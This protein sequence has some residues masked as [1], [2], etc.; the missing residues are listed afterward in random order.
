MSRPDRKKAPFH[1]PETVNSDYETKLGDPGSAPFTRGIYEEMYGKRLWTMRQY[2]GYA[3]AEESNRRYKYLLEQGINGLSVA[4]DLPTQIGYDSDNDLAKGEVGRVG[5]AVDSILDMEK[6]FDG[7]DLGSVSTSMTI[8]ATAPTLL[9][10]Y[11][12]VAES[13][14]VEAASLTGTVQNDILKEYIARGTYIYPP[15]QSMRL[16]TDLFAYCAEQMPNWNTISISGY[17]IREAGATAAQEL[18]FTFANAIAYSEAAVD[19]GLDFDSFA[20]RLSFFFNCHSDF[21]EEAA[22]FRAARRIWT[23]IAKERFKSKNPKS[24][25]LRFHTQTAGSSLTA[26]QPNVNIVRTTLQALA[27]VLGGTQ[28]LHTNSF[29]EALSL[30]T[31]EAAL[32]ALR[33]QQ[34]IAHEIGIENSADPLGG[35]WY[36]EN[37]TDE[38][39]T[40][41]FDY[42]KKIDDIGGALNAIEN[43]FIQNEIA[44]SAYEYQKAVEEGAKL[45]VGVNAFESEQEIEPETF[46]INPD[47]LEKQMEKL[48]L[49]KKER[50]SAAVERSLSELSRAAETAENTMPKI[51]NCV[52]AKS[53]LGEISDAMRKVFG[54]YKP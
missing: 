40:E 8:N 12:A 30:P 24:M 52:K 44:H 2:A 22:K 17:H 45:I 38:L 31:E 29:D 23:T 43:G 5:V 25:A 42:I 53:T 7:I 21:F 4:F 32:L 14:G 39:E 28:S 13:K 37:L 36:V 16:I 26:Q 41:T 49:L 15:R 50:D 18:A 34:V 1:R 48:E 27:A 54:E 6:L 47:V 11:A 51:L 10:L 46:E 35:S 9:A 3:S 19:A 20:P 33:T